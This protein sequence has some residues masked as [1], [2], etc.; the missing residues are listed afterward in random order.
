MR[1]WRRRKKKFEDREGEAETRACCVWRG[2]IVQGHL[3]GQVEMETGTF[4]GNSVELKEGNEGD[5]K[6]GMGRGNG[7][8][9]RE[10][11]QG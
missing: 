6:Y 11:K 1:R 2:G 8:G 10:A 7:S 9:E 5:W 4:Q 3:L